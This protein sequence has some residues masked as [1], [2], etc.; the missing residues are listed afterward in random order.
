MVVYLEL[1]DLRLG[2]FLYQMYRNPINLRIQKLSC[3]LILVKSRG[4]TL[5]NDARTTTI[6]DLHNSYG[7]LME[8]LENYPFLKFIKLC[9]HVQ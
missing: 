5:P 3:E 2:E 9:V 1:R 6:L 4:F 8:T 7:Y